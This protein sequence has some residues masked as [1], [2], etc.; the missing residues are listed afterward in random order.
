LA[1]CAASTGNS[2]KQCPPHLPAG[3]LKKLLKPVRSSL[4]IWKGCQG[5]CGSPGDM[6]VFVNSS[7][8]VFPNFVTCAKTCAKLVPIRHAPHSLDMCKSVVPCLRADMHQT[9]A[10]LAPDLRRRARRASKV[11]QKGPRNLGKTREGHDKGGLQTPPHEKL[12]TQCIPQ[13]STG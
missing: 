3:L 9:C 12:H 10:K 1:W 6:A 2:P 13:G 7:A 5:T 8:R 4:I 11:S